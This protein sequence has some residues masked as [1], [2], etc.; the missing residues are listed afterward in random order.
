MQLARNV[1]AN[2]VYEAK[3][4][5]HTNPG[6]VTGEVSRS[7]S[8]LSF[9]SSENDFIVRSGVIRAMTISSAVKYEET[10]ASIPA[11]KVNMQNTKLDIAKNIAI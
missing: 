11:R 10:L 4:F 2:I 1:I 6:S 9:L 8:V 5:A 3:N 7:C